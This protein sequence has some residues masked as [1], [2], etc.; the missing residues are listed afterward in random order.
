MDKEKEEYKRLIKD[1]IEGL[2]NRGLKELKNKFAKLLILLN[3]ED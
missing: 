2:E 1:I 3:L